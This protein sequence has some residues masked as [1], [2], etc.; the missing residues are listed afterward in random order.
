MKKEILFHDETL[1]MNPEAFDFDFV[2]E[3]FMFRQE[4]MQEL[5]S[6]V[7][8]ATHRKRPV[9]CILCGDPATGKTTSI[10]KIFEELKEY[11]HIITV[12]INSR[13]HNTTF[14]VYSEIN[15]KLFGYTPPE[16]GIPVTS[17]Y[18]K[19]FE[20]LKEENKVLLIALDDCVFLEDPDEV[21]YQLSR[22]NEVY[23][24][25]K[26]GILAVLSEKEKY[27]IEDKSAS[28]FRPRIIEYFL[29][30]EEEILEILKIRAKI[31]FYP[32]VVNEDI[33]RI[34]ANHALEQ[35]L[36][37]GIELLRQSA[38]EAEC[39]S[40]RKILESHVEKAFSSILKKVKPGKEIDEKEKTIL[41]ILAV[42]NYNSGELYKLANKKLKFSYS[43][44]YR[45]IEKLE[46]KKLI[47]S[48]EKVTNLGRTRIIS[49]A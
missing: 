13:V 21:I 46:K 11:S 41:D 31:G 9:N 16:S 24:G 3:E 49:K 44:F 10:K 35:D 42:K 30:E 18:Q 6:C 29:Y 5:I 26:V 25:V 43:S 4:Q 34:I 33:L 19:I 17:L 36:R 37:F 48:T 7:N 28:V 47:I 14:R 2:P 8:P 45:I 38:I 39:K 23:P 27:I 40:E 20:K 32:G 22:A 1:F 12:Y 15:R